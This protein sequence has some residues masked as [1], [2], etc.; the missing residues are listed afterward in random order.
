MNP[1]AWKNGST[2]IIRSLLPSENSWPNPSVLERMLWWESITPFGIPVVPLENITVASES[3]PCFSRLYRIRRRHE[4]SKKATMLIQGFCKGVISFITSSRRTV[5]F[6][7]WSFALAMNVRE[8][9]VVRMPHCSAADAIA[10]RPAV[11]LILTGIL[12]ASSTA[13]FAKAPPI[14]AGNRSPIIESFGHCFRNHRASNRLATSAF[15]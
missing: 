14:D 15:P 7:A 5:S 4:G 6:M 3:G 1:K 11:K 8:V 13:I 2:P 12:P 9:K 10:S